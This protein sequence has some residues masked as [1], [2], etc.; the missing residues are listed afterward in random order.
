[1]FGF[2]RNEWGNEERFNH[3]NGLKEQNGIYDSKKKFGNRVRYTY[4]GLI[5]L[6]SL[7]CL[8]V[9]YLVFIRTKN[10]AGE[11]LETQAP[12]TQAPTPEPTKTQSPTPAPTP[13]PN[14]LERLGAAIP[15]KEIDW[16][17][18]KKKNEDVYAWIYVP[19]TKID[20]PV[21]QHPTDNEF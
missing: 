7:V 12:V 19:G 4:V 9:V 17:G 14:L 6:V 18:L 20:Y 8:L 1:M 10:D 16:E 11:V 21:A 15:E 3:N 13:E 5:V 2:M